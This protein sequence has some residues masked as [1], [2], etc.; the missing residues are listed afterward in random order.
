MP[1]FHVNEPVPSPLPA[2][3]VGFPGSLGSVRNGVIFAY[4]SRAD[5]AAY[6]SDEMHN[7]SAKGVR[8]YIENGTIGTTTLTVKIQ[9]RNP[10]FNSSALEWVDLPGAVTAALTTDASRVTLTVYP[11]I[12][13]TA[14]ESVS[15]HL[16]PAWRVVATLN[17]GDTNSVPFSVG[18]DYLL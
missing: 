15:D 18:G 16:G 9:V 8:L 7:L 11:G 1:D 2:R 13:E 4:E 17:D 3:G 12:A 10:A 5:N 14:N 6:T